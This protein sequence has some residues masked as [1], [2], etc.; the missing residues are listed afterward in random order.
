MKLKAV[1]K[2]NRNSE[3]TKEG[4]GALLQLRTTQ[5]KLVILISAESGKDTSDVETTW[6]RGETIDSGC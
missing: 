4:T 5:L 2:Q 3:R 1:E 6:Y